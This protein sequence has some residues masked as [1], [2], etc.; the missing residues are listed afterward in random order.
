MRNQRLEF[1]WLR[2]AAL[3]VLFLMGMTHHGGARGVPGPTNDKANDDFVRGRILVR[4]RD[5]TLPA[6]ARQ[7]IAALGARDADEIPNIGVHILDLPYQASEHAFVNSFQARTE[8]EFAELDRIV[9]PADVI[10]N[11][12]WYAN[13][14]WHLKKIESPVAWS[15]TTGSAN[16]VIAILDTG[17]EGTHEDLAS[18]M[19]IGWNAY[20][21]NSNSAD[22]GGHGTAVAGTAAAASNNGLGVASVC[23]ACKIMPIRVSDTSGYATYSAI[24]NGLIWAGDRGARVANISYIVSESSTVTSAAKYFQGKGGVVT[25]SAGNYGTFSKALDNPYILTV[26]ATDRYDALYT[27]SNRGN[28]IDVAAPGDSYSTKLGG[29]YVSVGGT[30]YSAPTVAGVAALVISANPALSGPQV[31]DI[32]KQSADDLGTAGW[33]TNYGHGRVNAARAVNL[34]LGGHGGASDTTPPTVS[35]TFPAGV[36][37]LSGV[38]DVQI[39]AADD[40]GVASIA[41]IVDGMPVG[42]AAASTYASHWD[43]TL[44][45]NGLH[46]FTAI[47]S[48]LAGNSSSVSITVNINNSLDTTPPLVVITSPSDGSKVSVNVPV[49]VNASDERGVT[50]VELYVD[51]VLAATSI[52]SPFAT[53][54]NSKKAAAGKHILQCKAYDG[55]GNMGVSQIVNVIR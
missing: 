40:V 7:I 41:F 10:P 25:S 23:W 55:A 22:V 24:A 28:N 5:G 42:T 3:I 6:H 8:V 2:V 12:P 13:W 43:T 34:A 45:Q 27:W 48:D 35:F 4:F 37:N 30:S 47:A 44:V 31:Q 1:T 38:V 21:D 9:A 46:N 14:E 52:S 26:S 17:V 54:W 51:G 36:S 50:K 18:K 32:L 15:M 33:D 16:V 19:A 29:G 39:S 53:K 49:N 20:N 11:D